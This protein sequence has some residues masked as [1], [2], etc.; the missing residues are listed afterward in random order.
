MDALR[1]GCGPRSLEELAGDPGAPIWIE[2][3]KLLEHERVTRQALAFNAR[4]VR[5]EEAMA[6]AP[7][8]EAAIEEMVRRTDEELA[9]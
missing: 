4:G 8:E 5:L 7:S 1:L 9:Q 3:S 2:A 6:G